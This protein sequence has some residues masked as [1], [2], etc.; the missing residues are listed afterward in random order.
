[1]AI[2]RNLNANTEVI[3]SI[4]HL[5]SVPFVL[6]ISKDDIAEIIAVRILKFLFSM[7]EIS[8]LCYIS[9][10]YIETKLVPN[11]VFASKIICTVREG[12]PSF[13]S[14]MSSSNFVAKNRDQEGMTF[15]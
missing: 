5:L 2:L 4:A 11:L 3:E 12:N 10:V 14:S 9:Q 7:L 8:S 6:P 1:M 15:K 13:S